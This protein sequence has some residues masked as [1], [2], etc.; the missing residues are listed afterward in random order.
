AYPGRSLNLDE[1]RV[2]RIL[3]PADL[4]VTTVERAVLDLRTI[5]I[6]CHHLVADPAT[7]LAL[8]GES[9]ALSLRAQQHQITRATIKRDGKPRGRNAR[10]LHDR[11][12]IARQKPERLAQ[13]CNTFRPEAALEESPRLLRAEPPRGTRAAANRTQ[14]VRHRFRF[15][16]RLRALEQR[17]A[18]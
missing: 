15:G 16:E 18:A 5:E 13:T 14:R 6:G 8:V 7:H 4:E 3:D 1:Q 12:V 10:S 2:D 9:L 11:L 17:T